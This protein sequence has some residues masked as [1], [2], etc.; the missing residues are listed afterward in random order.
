MQRSGIM[1]REGQSSSSCQYE[2][3][4]RRKFASCSYRNH[5]VEARAGSWSQDLDNPHRAG[6]LKRRASHGQTTGQIVSHSF[7]SRHSRTAEAF[8]VPDPLAP[9]A[10]LSIS[11]APKKTKRGRPSSQVPQIDSLKPLPSKRHAQGSWCFCPPSSSRWPEIV[12][13]GCAREN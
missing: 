7:I 6:G 10:S 12:A 11:S 4:G 13:W 8:D 2:S 5:K 1:L 9:R 3:A